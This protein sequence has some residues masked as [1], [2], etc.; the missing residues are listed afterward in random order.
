MLF[1]EYDRFPEGGGGGDRHGPPPGRGISLPPEMKRTVETLL[2]RWVDLLIVG[3][4]LFSWGS[5]VFFEISKYGEARG[6]VRI[7]ARQEA[8]RAGAEFAGNLSSRFIDL[9]FVASLFSGSDAVRPGPE[10]KRDVRIFVALHPAMVDFELERGES[11]PVLWSTRGGGGP[12][13]GSPMATHS[14]VPLSLNPSLRIGRP[15]YSSSVGTRLLPLGA[16]VPGSSLYVRTHVRMDALLPAVFEGTS[17]FRVG[18]SSS[19]LLLPSSSPP[20]DQRFVFPD[21]SGAGV[22]L[23]LCGHRLLAPQDRLSPL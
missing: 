23:P 18:I 7:E 2:S 9:G 8:L 19:G 5:I 6:H 1:P 3:I 14:L 20:P 17:S 21:P 15:F 13:L 12:P 10:L 16:L 4:L 11:G 22:R